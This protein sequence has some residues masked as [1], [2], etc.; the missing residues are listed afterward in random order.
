[1]MTGNRTDGIRSCLNSYR[2]MREGT[3]EDLSCLILEKGAVLLRSSQTGKTS[4]LDLMMTSKSIQAFK[5]LFY[6]SFAQLIS[7][8]TFDDI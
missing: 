5:H 7:G 6:V 3:I 1:M 2:T 4:L 8:R